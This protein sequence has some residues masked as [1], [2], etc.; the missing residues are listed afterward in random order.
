MNDDQL[1]AAFTAELQRDVQLTRASAA[2]L[3][4][5]ARRD[6]IVE[7][8]ARDA[9]SRRIADRVFGVVELFAADVAAAA[10]ILPAGGLVIAVIGAA[11]IHMAG[12]LALMV[13]A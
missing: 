4:N 7:Q 3:W 11:I 8:Y 2:D 13:R 12:T 1:K 10:L 9:R 5:R 6:E